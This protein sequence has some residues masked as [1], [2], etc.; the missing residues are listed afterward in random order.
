MLRLP[1]LAV[2][3]LAM[4][5]PASAQAA[6]EGP[7]DRVLGAVVQSDGRVDYRALASRHRDDLD[8]ALAAIARQDPGALRTDAQKTTFL[9]N[10]YNAHVL[11]RVLAHPRA[12][13]LERQDLFGAFF[14]Q[15]VVVAG[16]TMTLD[17]L[18]HGVLRR[19]DR[20]AGAPVP[21]ALRALRPSRVDYRIHAALNCAAVSCPPLRARSYR[22]ATLDAD[23][24]ARFRL[25]VASSRAVRADGRRLV[26]SSLFDW[27]AGDF[28]SGGRR[29]GDVLLAAMSA[30]RAASLRSRLAGKAAADLRRDR[31]VT[32]A[33][34][35]TV[36]RAR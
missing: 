20:V 35:W 23:L 6:V 30:D 14:R 5:A 27:F 2:F 16:Q 21:R 33:Y 7:L 12:T 9:I 25:F 13:N 15:P 28:E 26:V 10:A 22:A 1:L 24:D 32:F 18:E 19:Q 34:D 8:A 29:V 17:Q 31:A 3:L 4:A 11:A 36:N